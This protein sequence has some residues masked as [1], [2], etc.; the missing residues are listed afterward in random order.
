M[1]EQNP[2]KL[3]VELIVLLFLKSIVVERALQALSLIDQFNFSHSVF[4]AQMFF[5]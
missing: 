4:L 5:E 2:H 3:D 1:H